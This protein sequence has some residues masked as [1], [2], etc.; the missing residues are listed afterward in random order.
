MTK[1]GEK[2]GISD[3]AVRKWFRKYGSE[4]PKC[5]RA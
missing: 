1:I 4:I 3:N 2:Y 5:K